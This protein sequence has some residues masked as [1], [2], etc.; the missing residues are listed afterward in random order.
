MQSRLDAWVKKGGKKEKLWE[1]VSGAEKR[2]GVV[3]S[4]GVGAIAGKEA[5]AKIKKDRS[6]RE[7]KS[8]DSLLDR[9][10]KLRE[11]IKKGIEV[12]SW[13]ERLLE[14][15]EARADRVDK[16]GWDQ[17]LCFGDDEWADFGAEVFESY[18]EGDGDDAMQVDGAGEWWCPGP[19]KCNRH[20]G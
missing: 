16:C 9:I 14:L 2:E 20:V 18:E 10:V 3:V 7:N 5:M 15:A 1:T 12:L 8:L 19:R 17:R 11:E 6:D 13:R 4:T